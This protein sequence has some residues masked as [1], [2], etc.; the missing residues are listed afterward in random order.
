MTFVAQNNVTTAFNLR[1]KSF[2]RAIETNI[3]P[4]DT[5]AKIYLARQSTGKPKK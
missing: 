1:K 4:E 5:E 2:F 3:E